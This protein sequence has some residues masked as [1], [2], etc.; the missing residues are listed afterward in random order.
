MKRIF[1]TSILILAAACLFGCGPVM[2]SGTPAI[3][4]ENMMCQIR[5]GVTDKAM[6]YQLLGAPMSS[7][8]LQSGEIWIYH[9]REVNRKFKLIGWGGL[10]DSTIDSQSTSISITFDNRGIVKSISGRPQQTVKPQPP[11]KET[12]GKEKTIPIIID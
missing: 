6:V 5:P 10:F 7:H 11:T 8:N 12:E 2:T 3:K 1:G 4:N 9:Y